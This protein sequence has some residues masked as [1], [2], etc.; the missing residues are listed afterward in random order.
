[1]KHIAFPEIG[2]FRQAIRNV[3]VKAQRIGTDAN[4]DAIYDS[5]KPLPKLKYKGTV[6]CHGSNGGVNYNLNTN[7]YAIQSR[8]Q[9]ITVEKD[10]FG[11]ARFMST[12]DMKALFA[13]V[14]RPE[15][16]KL[17]LPTPEEQTD[18][19][20]SIVIY[21]EWCGGSIQKTVAL[22]KLEKMFVVF[23]VLYRGVWLS[24]EAVKQIKLPEQRIFNINDFTSYE[25]EVDFQ[26]P[27]LVQNNLGE[28]TIGVENECPVAK[29]LGSIGTGE[30]VVWKG[31]DPEYSGPEFWFKV[32]GAKHSASNVKEL[33]NV[34]V[35]KVKSVNELMDKVVTENR[36]SQG[37]QVLKSKMNIADLTRAHTGD[38]IRWV[39]DDVIKEESDTIAASSLQQ[40]ELGGAVAKRVKEW[41]FKNVV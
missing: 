40:K 41:F 32:K 27:D 16:G 4:G 10:N 26:N 25:I 22:A 19:Q 35:E 29:A 3:K 33:A 14:P 9:I 15:E 30:G 21:G 37:V 28:I 1:M 36:M 8:E 17:G 7:E 12:V 34:D 18:E 6:K 38:L 5:L 13:L 24:E 11:F 39:F 2:Q 31:I 20:Q 23:A